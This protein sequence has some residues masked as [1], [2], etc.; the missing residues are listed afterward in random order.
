L[1]LTT[2]EFPIVSVCGVLFVGV[3][4]LEF[5]VG[6]GAVSCI[7][8]V[9]WLDFH[10][11]FLSLSSLYLLDKALNCCYVVLKGSSPLRLV[12]GQLA[13][14]IQKMDHAEPTVILGATIHYEQWQG[15]NECLQVTQRHWP[16]L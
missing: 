14:Y 7:Y 8:R 15:L 16:Y 6:F 13:Y 9:N 10:R 2:K 12:L 1:R 3:W 4:G 5:G 11:K